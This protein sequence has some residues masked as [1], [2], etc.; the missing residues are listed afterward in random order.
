MCLIIW[1]L[2]RLSVTLT[3]SDFGVPAI[4]LQSAS[5]EMGFDADFIYILATIEATEYNYSTEDDVG[6]VTY[7]ATILTMTFTSGV[8]DYG[9]FNQPVTIDMRLIKKTL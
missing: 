3:L 9:L 1:R 5:T 4:Y 8:W 2:L 7:G 6:T